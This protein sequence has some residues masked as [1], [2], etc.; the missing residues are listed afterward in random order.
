MLVSDINCPVVFPFNLGFFETELREI[1]NTQASVKQQKSKNSAVFPNR[2]RIVHKSQSIMH[3]LRVRL[4]INTARRK[5][6]RCIYFLCF[7]IIIITKTYGL[8]EN[9]LQL[10]L[11]TAHERRNAAIV[12]IDIRIKNL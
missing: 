4:G 10:L 9:F 6:K 3:R 11:L 7:Q 8:N 1:V 5:V 12:I 2:R